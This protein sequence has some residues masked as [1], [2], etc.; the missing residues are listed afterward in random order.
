[1]MFRASPVEGL[2]WV[3]GASSGIGRA[4]AIELARRGYT[5]AATAR[6][7]ALLDEL[8]ASE[9]LIHAFPGDLTEPDETA[10]LVGA[11]EAAHGPIAL[12]FLNAAVYF[13]AERK[14]FNAALAWR[15]FEINVGGVINSL[16]PVLAAMT[17][18]GKGQI[19]ITSSL[20]GYGGIPGS[21]AYG[22][23]KAALIYMAE[24]LKLTYEDAGLRV[25]IVNPG[26]V[27]TPMTDHNTSF[28]MPFIIDAE[29]AARIICDGFERGG[30]EIAFPRRL[31][32]MFKAA[33]LLPYPLFF[34]LM[35]RATRRA[36]T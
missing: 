36:R 25:Q 10:S 29:A 2:A 7:A 8:A 15:T 24:A 23:T 5:V 31:A 14:T 9:P 21:L 11:I 33:R 19:A 28:S 6:R 1:M 13:P 4:V 30:F 3:T 12:A 16:G 32:Y 18:R 17:S 26:F 22:S 20:A 35:D 34:R 27:R